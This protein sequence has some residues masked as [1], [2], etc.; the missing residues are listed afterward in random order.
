MRVGMEERMAAWVAFL[1]AHSVVVERLNRELEDGHGLPLTWYEVLLRLEMT[2]DGRLRMLDLA[3]T[4][5]LSKS[6]VTR[7]VDRMEA[8]GLVARQPSPRDRRVIWA[9][10]TS[11]GRVAFDEAAPV[12]LRGVERHF[13]SAMTAEEVR[14]LLAALTKVLRANGHPDEACH[15]PKDFRVVAEACAGQA[16]RAVTP[17]R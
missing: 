10:I 9:A 16:A 2:P 4:L 6:G 17:A 7:L 12:H 1:Q 5:L 11:K 3:R 8:A 14:G 15:A 13:M